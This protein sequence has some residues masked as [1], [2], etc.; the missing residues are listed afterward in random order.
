[1]A[2]SHQVLMA[3]GERVVGDAMNPGWDHALGLARQKDTRCVHRP[4]PQDT[5]DD[6]GGDDDD[7]NDD[8]DDDDD[9]NGGEDR[10][11]DPRGSHCCSSPRSQRT[12][13]CRR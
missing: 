12:Y 9:V 7:V 5:I 8:D 2:V 4:W 3:P 1:M 13:D 10:G 6:G 11:S